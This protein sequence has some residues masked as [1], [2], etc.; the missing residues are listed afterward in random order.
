MTTTALILIVAGVMI[1]A[2]LSIIGRD[3]RRRKRRAFV[4]GRDAAPQP[5]ATAPE[6]E[7][8]ITVASAARSGE[9]GAGTGD[10]SVGG[11]GRLGEDG[12]ITGADAQRLPS[13]EQRWAALQ[14]VINAGVT[15]VNGVLGPA[16]VVVSASGDP[17][18]S[19]KN[20]GYG[21]YR[22]VLIGNE[23]VGWLR[24]ELSADNRLNG[25]VKAHKE[26]RAS[27]NAVASIPLEG[28]TPAH[29]SDLLSQCLRPTALYATEMARATTL[30]KDASQK[31]WSAVEGMINAALKAT[32]GALAQAGATLQP[33]APAA[34]ENGIRRH[35]LTV[36]VR[37]NGNDVARMLIER[38]G[39]EVE[40]AV[41]VRD[42]NLVDLGR[43]RRISV[44]GMTIHG[45]AELIAG[46]AWPT[47][48][49]FRETR[50]SG[51]PL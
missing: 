1:G 29:A 47:I 30:E 22:R 28:L 46:C 23:S 41:G 20:R 11:E 33:L 32:N 27:L 3:M 26:S 39:D 49:H 44:N 10:A 51:P 31:G 24:L 38:P 42:A 48:A 21:A 4:S 14:P 12:M 36:A 17:T 19:Y 2:G 34:W 7:V 15:Q 40:V 50:G 37:V 8:E 13:L 18:W 16:N 25:N 6:S 45:L 35:R 5:G 9:L 43:R